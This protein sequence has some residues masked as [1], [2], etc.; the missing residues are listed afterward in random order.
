MGCEII[1]METEVAKMSWKRSEEVGRFRYTGLVGDGDAAVM[2]ALST[3]SPYPVC[4]EEC[5]NHVAKRM[6]MILH[7]CVSWSQTAMKVFKAMNR[8]KL[9]KG[10]LKFTLP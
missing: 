10:K 7:I 6:F 4:K 5:I 2:D 3:T 1:K 9:S 8:T